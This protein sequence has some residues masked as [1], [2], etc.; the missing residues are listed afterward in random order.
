MVA[1]DALSIG[2]LSSILPRAGRIVPAAATITASR[3]FIFQ[4]SVGVLVAVPPI[5]RS[6]RSLSDPIVESELLFTD[7]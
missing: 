5:L 1:W 4:H 7:T 3:M 6:Q 2:S